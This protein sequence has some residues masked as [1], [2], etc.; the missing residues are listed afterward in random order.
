AAIVAQVKALLAQE[1][2]NDR[3]SFDE[4]FIHQ[5]WCYGRSQG[6]YEP[7]WSTAIAVIRPADSYGDRIS[8]GIDDIANGGNTNRDSASGSA[9]DIGP[10]APVREFSPTV[11][12]PSPPPGPEAAIAQAL[13]KILSP[14][15]IAVMAR[16]KPYGDAERLWVACQASYSPAPNL[17]AQ[18]I[19][20]ELRRLA[21]DGVRD[22]VVMVKVR[23]ET[24]VDW[25]VKIDLTPA[26]E[27]LQGWAHW[28]D[29]DAITRLLNGQLQT[30]RLQGQLT[31][32]ELVGACLQFTYSPP[33]SVAT[34]RHQER[35]VN[36]KRVCSALSAYLKNLAPQ[37]IARL[38]LAEVH[39]D[40]PN[41]QRP[42]AEDGV[43]VKSPWD[44]AR[45]GE[46]A[47]IRFLLS[48]LLNPDLDQQL[49]TGGIR[50]QVLLKN[51]LL[52]VMCDGPC[53][54]EQEV[55][56]SV[57]GL[58]AQLAVP[59]IHGVRVYGRRAGQ[60]RPR[61]RM[62]S[63]F[64]RQNFVP[65]PPPA[66]AATDAYVTE[67]VSPEAAQDS[68][69]TQP[70]EV[71]PEVGGA[72]PP[73]VAVQPVAANPQLRLPTWRWR[74]ALKTTGQRTRLLL[75][76][77]QLFTPSRTA[78]DLV[79]PSRNSIL[80]LQVAMVWGVVGLLLFTQA[81]L[82]TG[83]LMDAQASASNVVQAKASAAEPPLTGT[84][85]DADAAA[86]IQASPY[87]PFNNPQLDLKL[88]LYHQRLQTAGP[89]DVIVIGSS[90]AMRGVEPAVL[91]TELEA[92][93]YPNATVFN[94]GVN[95]ATAQVVE[96][97]LRRILQ[98]E[99]L[100]QLVIW[101]DG[102][103]AFKQ[104]ATD[105]TYQA[106]LTSEGYQALE[107]G[108]LGDVADPSTE[109]AAI[110]DSPSSS[111]DA[112]PSLLHRHY[113]RLDQWL[114]ERLGEISTAHPHRDRIK[115][116]IAERFRFFV[117]QGAEAEVES[118][119][120]PVAE[121]GEAA[122]SVSL[123]QAFAVAKVD[124]SGFL[125]IT[126]RFDPATYYQQYARVPGNYDKDYAGFELRG[127][128][129]E[130]LQQIIDLATAQEMTVVFANTPLTQEYLDPFRAGHEQTFRQYMIDTALQHD[131]FVFRDLSRLWAQRDDSHQFFSDPSHL[132]RYGAVELSAHLAGD[133]LV[134]WSLI[135]RP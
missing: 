73:E 54:P 1:N 134:P 124:A 10:E 36:L 23:G 31:G 55:A 121:A 93:G 117:A 16:I 53:C 17:I 127:A 135:E 99:Q 119:A 74:K 69:V 39:P 63:N 106:M 123:A 80:D 56:R 19:S 95:G 132:N 71:G 105:Q 44:L 114:S 108:E 75:L 59:S 109:A 11:V 81:D 34:Y 8:G 84:L 78:Q 46:L 13:A 85:S 90:R 125:P 28:G 14:L 22:A 49:A 62:G 128:Q 92:L 24:Q 110:A 101:A 40:V 68:E 48:R 29:I 50:V 131:A 122:S 35:V 38:Q 97:I 41:V 18:P 104:V 86:L 83:W 98:P 26:D 79:H 45:A 21:P 94:F 7:A 37:G 9:T 126:A 72:A 70:L 58:V 88:A 27:I 82:A 96:V 120:E 6:A 42:I 77:S 100:P 47:A 3:L 61:W 91:M 118:A 51:Q 130:A 30:Q 133:P 67:L 32:G 33:P 20:A 57:Q 65:E 76:K 25:L 89:P 102:A 66:F 129:T 107:A 4:P 103:R 116:W 15:G 12:P 5:L 112:S 52:H 2:I 87:P 115:A 111:D 64:D 43:S 60:R 113:Q